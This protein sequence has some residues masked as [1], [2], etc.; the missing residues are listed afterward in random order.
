MDSNNLKP[1]AF[2]GVYLYLTAS[3]ASG[4]Q[5]NG[6]SFSSLVTK[7]SLVPCSSLRVARPPF[8][9]RRVKFNKKYV[10]NICLKLFAL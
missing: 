10:Y 3:V 7:A 8:H 4:Q 9:I 5:S 2:A 1:A 6:I